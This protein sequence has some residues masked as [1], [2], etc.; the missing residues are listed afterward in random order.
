M[1]LPAGKKAHANLF[2]KWKTVAGSVINYSEVT[3]VKHIWMKELNLNDEEVNQ[4]TDGK[5]TIFNFT[6]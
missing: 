5:E 3:N 4:L 1:M 6:I 2:A